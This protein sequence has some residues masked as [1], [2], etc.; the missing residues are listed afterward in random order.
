MK[1]DALK[2][3]FPHDIF[4]MR[5]EFLFLMISCTIIGMPEEVNKFL[6]TEML[7]ASLYKNKEMWYNCQ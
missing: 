1:F 7:T 5:M 6:S 4:Y 3:N 2:S